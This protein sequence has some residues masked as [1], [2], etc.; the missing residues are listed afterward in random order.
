MIIKRARQFA[1]VS[2]KTCFWIYPNRR[3]SDR[4]IQ[5]SYLILQ[6][7]IGCVIEIGGVWWWIS[8][9]CG[10]IQTQMFSDPPER[11]YFS[12]TVCPFC[13]LLSANSLKMTNSQPLSLL[14]L[15]LSCN[16][17]PSMCNSCDVTTCPDTLSRSVAIT[18]SWRLCSPFQT[19]EMWCFNW[20]L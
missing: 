1:P 3:T 14:H 20:W 18:T 2:L 12:L 6:L 17:F 19:A 11:F 7:C 13:I 10:K 9:C 15:T 8:F 4:G 5:S 16:T